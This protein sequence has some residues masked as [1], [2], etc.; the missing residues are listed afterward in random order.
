MNTKNSSS[1]NLNF[2]GEFS[3]ELYDMDLE[4]IKDCLYVQYLKIK[5]FY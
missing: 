3:A 4:K 1:E 5:Y 2:R